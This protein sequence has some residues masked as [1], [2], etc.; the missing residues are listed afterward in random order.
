MNSTQNVRINYES[1]G[2]DTSLHAVCASLLTA[3]VADT[4]LH[5]LRHPVPDSFMPESNWS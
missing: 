1:L 5:S 2:L 4:R 3:S